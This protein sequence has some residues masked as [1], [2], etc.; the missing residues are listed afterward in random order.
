MAH[1]TDPGKKLTELSCLVVVLGKGLPFCIPAQCA[2]RH[3]RVGF[4]T[5]LTKV[6]YLKLEPLRPWF[7]LLT[8]SR[9]AS[10]RYQIQ[11]SVQSRGSG[12]KTILLAQGIRLY[13]VNFEK[14]LN[15]LYYIQLYLHS[16]HLLA[17]ILYF[18]S[19]SFGL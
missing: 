13:S 17:P 7:L 12:T 15:V 4:F 1:L 3:G 8:L 18:I 9:L 5:S 14:V 2:A 6:H 10:N 19:A 11:E 16:W